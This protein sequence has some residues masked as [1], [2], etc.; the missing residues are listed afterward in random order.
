MRSGREGRP[1]HSGCTK[2]FKP[3]NPDEL[4]LLLPALSD[5]LPEG[6]LALF[7][8]DVVDALDLTPIFTTYQ[9]ATGGASHRTIRR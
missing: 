7:I 2:T 9:V 6:H 1:C 4:F 8:S 3:Y 5:W